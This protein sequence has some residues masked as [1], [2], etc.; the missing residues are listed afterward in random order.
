M[1]ILK[2]ALQT[3]ST[4][5]VLLPEDL[6]PML[7]E[8][9]LKLS[10]MYSLIPKVQ[11]SGKT[12]EW[13]QRT[14]VPSAWFEGE[15]SE[16]NTGVSTYARKSTQLKIM[17]MWGGVSGFMQSVSEMFVDALSTEIQG[18]MEGLNNILEWS[19]LHA[20]SADSYQFD[21][22]ESYILADTTARKSVA[23]GGNVVDVDAVVSLDV[24]DS[25][26]D[27]VNAQRGVES[28]RKVFLMSN[29]LQSK[30]SGL[31]TR[32]QRN[33]TAVEFESGFR[34][35]TYR[36][37]PILPTAYTTPLYTT[38]SPAVS[39]A[40]AAGGS[41][42]ANTYYYQIAS[43]TADG[44]QIAGTV[45]SGTTATTNL[46]LDLTWTA[47]ANAKLYKIYRGTT[48]GSDN[49]SLI[50]V[51]AAKTYDSA[52]NVSGNVAA[53]TDDGTATAITSQKPLSL[54]SSVVEEN[55][56]LVNLSDARGFKMLGKVSPLGER[57]QDMFNFVPLA[58]RKSAFEYMIEGF[59]GTM[60]PYPTAHAYARRCRT[61]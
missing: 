34:A 42:T 8:M 48:T 22:L 27:A 37:I 56:W 29:K 46:K 4:A 53:W 19:L 9:L 31:Q 33:V 16:Q 30:I 20:N 7:H 35:E 14:A 54:V 44:E 15:L 43:V 57:T 2:K 12:H 24:L 26:I 18:S 47:D 11:S 38:T 59:L 50:A 10:P 25:M 40:A 36:G 41:L 39:A 3:S 55:I 49:L 1:D 58:T 45:G 61:A 17:R 52:G 21:G 51:I 5:S 23:T 60:L 13:N 32:I 6:N 28:D